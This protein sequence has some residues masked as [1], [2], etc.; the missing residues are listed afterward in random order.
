MADLGTILVGNTTTALNNGTG[1]GTTVGSTPYLESI[2]GTDDATSYIHE[3]TN[4]TVTGSSLWM[5]MDNPPTDVG[6]VDTLSIQV[7]YAH[8]S[9]SADLT[10]DLLQAR[11]YKSDGT[12]PLTNALTIHSGYSSATWATSSVLNFTGVDTAA[13]QA[14]WDGAR[15]YFYWDK[16]RNKG[17][18]NGA[19]MAITA[20]QITGTYTAATSVIQI[21]PSAQIWAPFYTPAATVAAVRGLSRIE[22]G[23]SVNN[24]GLH[25]IGEQI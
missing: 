2:S 19:A 25:A 4:Q 8:L 13:N 17:G 6:N 23:A 9:P 24:Q 3:S 18:N 7:R 22:Y 12:T 1:T 15:I 11:V 10:W 5:D 16:S 14:D 20:A 21:I